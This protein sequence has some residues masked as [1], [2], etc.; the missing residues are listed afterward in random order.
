MP[1]LCG[2]KYDSIVITKS[3]KEIEN[4][5]IVRN[6]NFFPSTMSEI[7]AVCDLHDIVKL[8]L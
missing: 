5:N 7:C 8:A 3:D 4:K 1:Y 2:R 6:C